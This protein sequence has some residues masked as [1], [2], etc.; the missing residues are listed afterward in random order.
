MKQPVTKIGRFLWF[1]AT[2]CNR[3]YVVLVFNPYG[4]SW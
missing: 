2:Y 3:Q 4:I 1:V